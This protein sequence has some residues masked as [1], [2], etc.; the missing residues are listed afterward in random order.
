[1]KITS[2]VTEVQN[3]GIGME[4]LHPCISMFLLLG[5][6]W[7]KDT[8]TLALLLLKFFKNGTKIGEDVLIN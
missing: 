1:M 4:R 7:G 8:I 6:T 2:W 5:Q 3:I